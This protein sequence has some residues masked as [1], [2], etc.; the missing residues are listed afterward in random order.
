M[1]K[2]RARFVLIIL[3][4]LLTL[5]SKPQSPDPGKG[6]TR[7]TMATVVIEG[8]IVM[9][10][11]VERSIT[12]SGTLKPYEE[13]VLMPEVAGRIVTVNL[14]EGKPVQKGTILVKLFDLDLQAQLTKSKAQLDI[15]RATQMRLEA[16]IKI[17]GVSR[18]DYD[19]S[20]LQVNTLVADSVLLSVQISKTEV[21]APFNGVLGLKNVSPGAQVNTATPLTTIRAINKMKLDFSV[22]EKYSQE[23]VPGMM[24]TFSIEGDDSLYTAK[25]LASEQSIDATT[26]NLK[27]RAL[28]EDN[29]GLLKPGTFAR[30]VLQ[31]GAIENALMVPTQ[32]II[33]QERSKSVIV[34]VAGKAKLVAVKTGIRQESAVQVTEGLAAGDTVVTTGL[35][36]I[37]PGAALTFSKV[38]R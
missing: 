28:V 26:R 13:T 6:G 23:I 1:K 18:S 37:K 20:V 7:R 29:N 27:V 17:N 32:A 35:L 5:C 24:L 10:S 14:P 12:I 36:F 11:V 30:V 19:Q 34:A 33:P 25:V 16:L 15:A 4:A 2:T 3:L 22:P 8:F 9:P 38:T 31:L 21:R